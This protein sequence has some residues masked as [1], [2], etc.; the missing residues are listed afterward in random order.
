MTLLSDEEAN[1]VG[2]A[3]D[4]VSKTGPFLERVFGSLI[5]DSVGIVADKVKFYRLSK[6]VA[7][8]DRT[9]E[10]LRSRPHLRAVPPKFGLDLIEAATIEES[11]DL[12]ELWA[13]LLA[14]A[15][16][17]DFPGEMRVAFI[18]ILREMTPLDAKL[19]QAGCKMP[20]NHGAIMLDRPGAWFD[21][22]HADFRSVLGDEMMK[23]ATDRDKARSLYPISERET[24]AWQNLCR[25]GCAYSSRH[26][27][28]MGV[29]ITSLGAALVRAT[30][31]QGQAP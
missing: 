21:A 29:A 8:A 14:N 27:A 12:S 19:L 24:I 4:L 15:M 1:T 5:E 18:S 20:S 23:L 30:G 25:L 13:R 11:D 17:A 28:V 26:D 9:E 10:L 16:D 2:K 6:Y 22:R 31:D 3:I 7:L